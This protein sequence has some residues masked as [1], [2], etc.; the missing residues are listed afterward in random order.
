MTY[1]LIIGNIKLPTGQPWK[2]ASRTQQNDNK[3]ITGKRKKYGFPRKSKS[4]KL[5]EQINYQKRQRVEKNRRSDN[6]I[7]PI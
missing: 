2:L 5:V 6:D 4:I 7:K 3:R 1:H